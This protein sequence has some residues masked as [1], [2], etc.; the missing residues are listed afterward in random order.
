ME[1]TLAEVLE[2]GVAAQRAGEFQD[3]ERLYRSILAVQSDHPDANHNLG[4]LLAAHQ[5]IGEAIPLF[6]AAIRANPSVEQF[7]LS[8]IGALIKEHQFG[9]VRQALLDARQA[10]ASGE[11]LD[12]LETQ[13]TTA[14]PSN[15]KYKHFPLSSKRKRLADKKVSKKKSRHTA[16]LSEPPQ[17]LLNKLVGYYQSGQISQTEALARDLTAAFPSHYLAWKILGAALNQA[18]RN[19]ESVYFM[20]KASEL[21]PQDAESH[22]NLGIILRVLGRSEAAEKWHR[23]AIQLKGDYAEYHFNLGVLLSELGQLDAA[24]ACYRKAIEINPEYAKA[25]GNLGGILKR[26]RRFS[27]AEEAYRKAIT[28]HPD[29]HKALNNLG[30][31]LTDR[32]NIDGALSCYRQALLLSPDEVVTKSNLARALKRASFITADRS[33]YPILLDLL[34]TGN[35]GRPEDLVRSALSLLRHDPTIAALFTEAQAINDVRTVAVVADTAGRFPLLL[36]LM[37]LCPL[38]DMKF[39]ALLSRTR[40]LILRHLDE[41]DSNPPDMEF[42]SALSLQCFTNEYVYPESDDEEQRVLNLAAKI[43]SALAAG[44]QPLQREVLCLAT[45]RPIHLFHWCVNL[46]ALDDLVDVKARLLTQPLQE[47]EIAQNLPELRPISEHVSEKVRAQYEEN[48]YPR[49][50]KCRL[51]PLKLTIAAYFEECNIKFRQDRGTNLSAP[52]ILVAGSG[53]GRHPIETADRYTNCSVIAIDLSRTSLAYAKRSTKQLGI[54]N[55]HFLQA[56]ILDIEFLET[57][58]DVIESVGVLHH[59]REPMSGWKALVNQL[60]PGGLMKIGLYSDLARTSIAKIREEVA[61]L[62]LNSSDRDIRHFR[63]MLTSS[64]EPH[65]KAVATGYSD[66]YSLSE[67]RDLLFHVQEHRFSLIEIADTLRHLNLEFCGFEEKHIVS[68]FQQ[69]YGQSADIYD[70][71]SWHKFEEQ[72]PTTFMSMYQ[73]WCQRKD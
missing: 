21:A 28:I 15:K 53:T 69:F 25:H 60:K 8:L 63:N 44:R 35:F 4:L 68:S 47:R 65:H 9:G 14:K 6:R 3:A 27:E 1:L 18:G 43:S 23:K 40:S 48:P 45:Y 56:D 24:E 61:A 34:T 19:D 26:L 11:K 30:N 67:V 72:E 50:T 37:K 55:L 20:E 16:S 17:S 58:F 12:A 57:T 5:Q 29:N 33:L 13:I 49:W 62:N 52:N 32:G 46:K 71:E 73:F 42:L 64:E 38:P 41:L 22:N 7:W 2:R 36:E 66:V 10:G 51:R 59:M 54:K 39:E 70:L 31:L